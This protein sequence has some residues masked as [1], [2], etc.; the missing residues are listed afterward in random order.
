MTKP[1]PP[2]TDNSKLAELLHQQAQADDGLCFADFM[3]QALYHPQYG[4]YIVPRD[5]IG[6]SGDFFTS[7]SVNALFGRGKCTPA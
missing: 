1:L 6:K 4:Y 2:Q 5:R 7:S 3:A